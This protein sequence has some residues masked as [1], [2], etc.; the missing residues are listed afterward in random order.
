[1][2]PLS[3]Q[4]NT[5]SAAARPMKLSVSAQRKEA[6]AARRSDAAGVMT[7]SDTRDWLPPRKGVSAING[8]LNHVYDVQPRPIEHGS[9]T[10]GLHLERSVQNLLRQVIGTHEQVCLAQSPNQLGVEWI[11]AHSG[12]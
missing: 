2:R 1:M 12:L 6:L 9:P 7:V 5:L 10:P 8:L 11:E 3:P 4:T